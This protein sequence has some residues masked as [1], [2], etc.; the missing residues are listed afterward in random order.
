MT[1][2]KSIRFYN[3]YEVRAVWGEGVIE[4]LS[5]D[6]KKEMPQVDGHSVTNLRYCRRLYLLYSRTSEIHPQVGGKLQ[7]AEN[8]IYN[9]RNCEII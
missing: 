7:S 1:A 2:K 5:K 6:L 9:N 3:D 4:Q 8:Q